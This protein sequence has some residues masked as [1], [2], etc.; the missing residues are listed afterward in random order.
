M[1]RL[2]DLFRWRR[3]RLER[4]LGGLTPV[5][6]NVRDAWIW[7]WLDD[8]G[9]DIRHAVRTL[10]RTPTFTLTAVLSLALGIGANAAIF[11][12]VDQV[13]LRQLPVKDPQQIVLIDWRGNQLADGW[14]S[15]NLMSYP[16]CRDLQSQTPFFDGVFCR[17]PTTVNFSAGREHQPVLAEIVSGTYF[18]V[19]GVRPHFGRLIAESDDV[20]PDAHPVIVLSYDYWTNSLGSPA[21][22]VGRKV[23]LNNQ[24]MTVIGVAEPGFNGMDVGEAAML[25]V[26]A[27][28]KRQATPGWDRLLD[29][30]ARWMHVFARL[31]PGVTAASSMA[32]LRPWFTSVLQSDMTLESFPKT[33]PEQLR[34]FL[35]SY[36]EVTPASRGRSNMRRAMEGPLWVLMAGTS[37]LVLLACSNVA[38]LL[39]ARGAARGREVVTRIALGASRGR[40]TNQLLIESM[41]I[42][43]AGGV[44][45][46]LAAPAVSAALLSFLPQDIAR[47]SLTTDLDIR[48]L[49]FAL[50]V[51]IATGAL[52]GMAPALQAGRLPLITALRERAPSGGGVRL[53]RA[54]V[55]GQIAFTLIML[56]GAGL[57]LETVSSLHAKGPGF[58][59]DRLLMF[60]VDAAR[61]G[62]DDAAGSRLVL[63]LLDAVRHAP[64]VARAAI[65]GHT[66]LAGGSWNTSMTIEFNGRRATD[67][68]VH[69]SPVSP[70]FF[71]TLGARLIAGRDFDERAARHPDGTARRYRSAIVNASFARRYFGDASPIG[72][73]IGF[74]TRPDTKTDV[75]I[76][77]IVADFSYRGIREE[78][79][80]AFFPFLDIP[81]SGGTFY[82]RTHGKPETAFAEIR[83]TIGSVDST[84]PILSLRTIEEQINRSL[85]TERMM[86]TLLSGF[87]AVALLLSVIG[88]YGVMSF[89][90]TH[91]TREI[92]IRLALGATRVTAVWLVVRDALLMIGSGTAI[93]LLGSWVLGRVVA[94]QLFG[95]APIHAPTIALAALLLTVVA[96]GAAMVPAWR[97]SSVSPT[98][99]LHAE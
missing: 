98:E 95:V 74:G 29:R 83:A 49:L 34:S 42:S 38:S 2:L 47:A 4:E 86:A 25:W 7:R 77:G 87:S 30:R 85:T 41:V 8:C 23:L 37:L 75:E 43:L 89:V 79:E 80:Q 11:S 69:C 91:R 52:C 90:V 54:L 72:H 18:P 60:Q 65:A 45:G 58:E 22:I 5:R 26:P 14:G 61:S 46:I 93:A 78:T 96:L 1:A 63:R 84:L 67:R 19:L 71:S 62:Y 35:G 33:T 82:V 94:G 15:G 39:L 10:A 28:M 21:D 64:G 55:I 70:G 81:W 48:I 24:P 88:L 3:N 17:H 50:L 68:V 20:Q 16:M 59:R 76:V 73:R 57:F 44:L 97:A 40:I 6:E 51:S 31:K 53:R 9:R 12:L 13:L 32:G 92:G 66:L 56:I 36:L 99:A 27:M